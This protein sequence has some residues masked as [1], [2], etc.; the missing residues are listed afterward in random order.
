MDGQLIETRPSVGIDA[1]TFHFGFLSARTAA[2][3]SRYYENINDIDNASTKEKELFSSALEFIDSIISGKKFFEEKSGFK[4]SAKESMRELEAYGYA[5]DTLRLLKTLSR[6]SQE[7]KI[8]P[9]FD[10]IHTALQSVTAGM[11]E[12]KCSQE[13]LL[14]AKYFF[15]TISS[16][17]LRYAREQ[18]APR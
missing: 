18:H 9:L 7:E 16:I 3:L 5:I 1:D 2:A 6:I 17:L 10:K 13:D 14:I 4:K 8:G 15:E 12:K 11:G